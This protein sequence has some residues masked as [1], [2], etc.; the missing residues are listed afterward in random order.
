MNYVHSM[1]VGQPFCLL[2]WKLGNFFLEQTIQTRLEFIYEFFHGG[3]FGYVDGFVLCS[4]LKSIMRNKRHRGK[5][6]HIHAFNQ[7]KKK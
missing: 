3:V 7:T 5:L 2:S 1:D 6:L 4:M